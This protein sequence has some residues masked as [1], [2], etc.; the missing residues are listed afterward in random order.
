MKR[1]DKVTIKPIGVILSLLNGHIEYKNT[2]NFNYGRME[3]YCG[4]QGTIKK[5]WKNY[6]SDE[7]CKVALESDT[8]PQLSDWVWHVDWLIPEKNILEGDEL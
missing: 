2:I 3:R 1:G 8:E 4:K 5:V 6:S 7:I